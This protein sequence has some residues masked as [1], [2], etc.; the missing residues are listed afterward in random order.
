MCR[1][2]NFTGSSAANTFKTE[3]ALKAPL[4][5][6][7]ESGHSSGGARCSWQLGNLSPNW[8][9]H[10]K[11]P[12]KEAWQHIFSFE[13]RYSTSM[14]RP[15]GR[16]LSSPVKWSNSTNISVWFF[17]CWPPSLYRNSRTASGSV[18]NGGQPEGLE[19]EQVNFSQA[20]LLLL[21]VLYPSPQHQVA[22][23]Q[24]WNSYSWWPPLP[25]DQPTDWLRQSMEKHCFMWKQTSSVSLQHCLLSTTV[26]QWQGKKRSAVQELGLWV[27]WPHC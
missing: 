7:H 22:Q 3:G 12:F 14:G 9:C 6:N 18:I 10:T 4:Y 2:N 19:K 16:M 23:P 24:R 11:N 8:I 17:S 27:T 26:A 21:R 25:T 20:S 5:P 13:Q 1:I 15:C